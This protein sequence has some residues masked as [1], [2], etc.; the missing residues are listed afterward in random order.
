M[1]RDLLLVLRLRY[2][3]SEEDDPIGDQTSVG[4]MVATT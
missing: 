3:A 4:L 2:A 1:P